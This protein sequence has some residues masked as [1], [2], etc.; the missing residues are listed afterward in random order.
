MLS[1]DTECNE[2]RAAAA[3]R[4]NGEDVCLLLEVLK[5]KETYLVSVSSTISFVTH[6]NSLS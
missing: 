4:K 3:R 5:G 2:Q 1:A 6:A